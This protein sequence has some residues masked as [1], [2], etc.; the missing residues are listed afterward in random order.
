LDNLIKIVDALSEERLQE[1]NSVAGLSGIR[2]EET[3][4]KHLRKLPIGS[5]GIAVCVV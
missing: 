3:E 5:K 1:K 2:N 4:S